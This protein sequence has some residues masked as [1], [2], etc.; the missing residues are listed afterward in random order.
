MEPTRRWMSTSRGSF[1]PLGRRENRLGVIKTF[2]TIDAV[3]WAYGALV[4]IA[5]AAGV[6]RLH[7]SRDMPGL[8]A[9][10]LVLL[11]LPWSLVLQIEPFS[12]FGCVGMLVIVGG[13]VAANTVLLRKLSQRA[14]PPETS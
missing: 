12:H 6:V 5:V 10:E 3:S 2:R 14:K 4:L 8:A 9:I 1:A 7:E 13:G 11:A